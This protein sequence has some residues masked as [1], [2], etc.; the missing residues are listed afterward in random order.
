MVFEQVK[1]CSL[2][3][4]AKQLSF[5]SRDSRRKD[6]RRARCREC[7][8][9]PITAAE[10]E[11]RQVQ[12]L[13]HSTS[14]SA[15]HEALAIRR[16]QEACRTYLRDKITPTGYAL[17]AKRPIKRTVVL[18]LSDLHLGAD[19]SGRENP[20]PFG[21]VEEARRLEFVVRQAIDFKPQYRDQSELLLILNGDMIE[22]YLLHDLR[23]G[24]PLTEQMV[25]F[26]R[27]FRT[28]IG[29]LS[30]TFPRVRVECQP[31]NHGRDRMRH[32]SRATSSKWDGHEWR[33]YY[34]LAEM[35]SG[36]KNV[37]FNIPF[38]AVSVVDL[39]GS[40]LGITHG[41]TEVKLGPP[42][43]AAEAN[44]HTLD[45]INSTELYGCKID[46]WALGHY[47]T[48]RHQPRDPIVVWNG[49]LIPANGHG[50]SSGYIGEPC[51]QFLWEASPG[52][53]VGDVRFIKVGPEQDRDEKLG[54]LIEPFRF[55]L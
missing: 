12:R 31:G 51:G 3:Q 6:G 52:F 14:L 39:Y 32:P 34:A 4:T 2:C 22:G 16:F 20:V 15:A 40:K 13:R 25:V 17:K 47:H 5:F 46:A 21:K 33:M 48:P 38:R 23:D 54:K 18:L 10:L 41:D 30:Q 37:T 36:L 8:N 50:R 27:Y 43:R 9:P 53:P 11:D 35:C 42:D 1:T 26:W 7:E 44:A 55:D 45:R 28:I 49:G 19:L 29:V 24:A